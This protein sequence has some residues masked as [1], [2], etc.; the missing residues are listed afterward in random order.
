MRRC[1]IKVL[2]PIKKRK[3]KKEVKVLMNL[4]GAP[5]IVRLLDLVSSAF[6]MQTFLESVRDRMWALGA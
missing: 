6:Y 2:K 5:G 4:T 1:V 3:I